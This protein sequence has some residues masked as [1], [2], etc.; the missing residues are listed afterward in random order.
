MV[1]KDTQVQLC[2]EC[3]LYLITT[4]LMG[5]FPCPLCRCAALP[6]ILCWA[7]QCSEE[8]G[9]IHGRCSGGQPRQSPG[10]LTGQWR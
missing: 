2:E 6:L 9:P 7:G 3:P 1:K 10:E 4:V 8:G 5:V